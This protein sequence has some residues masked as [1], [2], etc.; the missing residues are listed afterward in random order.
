M[1]KIYTMIGSKKSSAGWSGNDINEAKNLEN[2]NIF[3]DRKN[4]IFP[5]CVYDFDF[6]P[7]WQPRFCCRKC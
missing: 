4:K 1:I 6:V 2:N 5:A 3:P 7:G